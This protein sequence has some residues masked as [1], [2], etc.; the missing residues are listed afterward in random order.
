[1]LQKHMTEWVVD[2][3]KGPIAT[4]VIKNINIRRKEREQAAVHCSIME[5][6]KD[7]VF[8]YDTIT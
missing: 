5:A 6:N 1:M 4:N 8:I 3:W 7:T 2:W